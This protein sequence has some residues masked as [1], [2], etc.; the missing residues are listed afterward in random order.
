M[1]SF[2]KIKV[3]VIEN[4][5]AVVLICTGSLIWSLTMIKS[6]LVYEYGMVFWGPNGHDGVWHIALAQSLAKGSW[7]MPIFAGEN[8]RNYHI[9]FDLILAAFHK[10]T[11]IPIHNLYFQLLPPLFAL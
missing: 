6:G 7:Q 4:I 3:L 10:L 2:E 1:K 9:G 11:F 5:W 8:I